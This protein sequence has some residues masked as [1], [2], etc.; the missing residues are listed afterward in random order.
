MVPPFTVF[1]DFCQF[2]KWKKREKGRTWSFDKGNVNGEKGL[3]TK[4][5]FSKFESTALQTLCFNSNSLSLL[6]TLYLTRSSTQERERVT[7]ASLSIS[8]T[9]NIKSPFAHSNTDTR[10]AYT[11]AAAFYLSEPTSHTNTRSLSLSLSPP[12]QW[13]NTVK[14]NLFVHINRSEVAITCYSSL[15]LYRR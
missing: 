2:L 15:S 1:K 5:Y 12:T 9:P 4:S 14:L 6:F 3:W 13:T 8:P 11:T 7:T 10:T